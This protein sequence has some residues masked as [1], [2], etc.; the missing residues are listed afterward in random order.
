VVKAFNSVGAALMIN[1]SFQQGSPT[2]FYCGE[3]ASAKEQ[4][5]AIVRQF[6]WQPYD[7]GGIVAS[8]AIEPLCIL[9]VSRGFQHNQWNHAFALLTA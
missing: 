9:W 3:N 1:P 5:S 2:M 8:R 7:C 4:V 6:G